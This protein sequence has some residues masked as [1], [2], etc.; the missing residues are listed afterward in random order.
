MSRALGQY[1][2]KLFLN[3]FFSPEAVEHGR[4][5]PSVSLRLNC[6][7][8]HQVGSVSYWFTPVFLLVAQNQSGEGKVACRRRKTIYRA[9]SCICPVLPQ[10]FSPGSSCLSHLFF[11]TV[12]LFYRKTAVLPGLHMA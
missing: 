6:G 10:S 12:L 1:V 5:R 7:V 2:L 8:L 9:K 3:F 11:P 4:V